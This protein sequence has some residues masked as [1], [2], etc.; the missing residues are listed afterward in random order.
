M[1][2]VNTDPDNGKAIKL[3]LRGAANGDSLLS[4]TVLLNPAL[5][6]AERANQTR[7]GTVEA[8]LTADI[9]TQ[10]RLGTDG[11]FE[12]PLW[13]ALN[14]L[15]KRDCNAPALDATTLQ[16][17]GDEATAAALGFATPSG[18]IS[19]TWYIIDVPGATT[20]SSAMTALEAVN[21]AGQ[22]ARG[23]YMQFPATAQAIDQP[24]RYTSDPLLVSAMLSGR[25][26]SVDGVVSEPT[27]AAVVQARAYDFPDLS[28]P[29]RLP[30]SPANAARTAYEVSRALTATAISNQF[31]VEKSI[32]AQ[33]DWVF[34][35]PTTRYSVGMDYTTRQ[36]TYS[37]V[38]PA[39][40]GPQYV[41]SQ[42]TTVQTNRVC[43]GSVTFYDYTRAGK[44]GIGNTVDTKFCGAATVVPIHQRALTNTF[45]PSM[46]SAS[47]ARGPQEL[48]IFLESHPAWPPATACCI[49]TSS[50]ARDRSL[51]YRPVAALRMTSR[52][53]ECVGRSM[54]KPDPIG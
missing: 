22:P 37:A 47:V 50:P 15:Y 39:G 35:M 3:R 36:P 32:S 34:S 13:K 17:I 48:P 33:T 8:I 24:E 1:H 31:S 10:Y 53:N 9:P 42:N 52:C 12:S 5:S 29:F 16:D 38:P 30:A 26:K 18:G 6:Q 44:R 51:R 25:V 11:S 54:V 46:L 23:N 21:A 19:G 40:E 43:F 20:F 14:P 49:H 41:H 45:T 2:L 28:T 27:A 7:E 4:M